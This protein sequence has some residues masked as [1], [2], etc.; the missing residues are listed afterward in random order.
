MKRRLA[1]AF[2]LLAVLSV[3]AAEPTPAPASAAPDVRRELDAVR[4]QL[5]ALDIEKALAA[6]ETILARSDLPEAARRGALDLRA[7]AHA[8][9]D[10][11][12][13][14]EKDY[15]A[16][17]AID[18]AYAPAREVTSKSAMDRF[19]KIQRSL[20]GTVHLDLDPKDAS[21][22][23]DDRPTP[24]SATGS[25]PA[26]AG[27]R[28]A[29]FTRKGFDALSVTIHVVAGQETLVQVHMVPNARGLIVRTDVDGVAVALD[30]A[31]LGVTARGAG[32][33]GAPAELLLPDVGI[34]EHE[35]RFTK[36][37]FASESVQQAVSVDLTDRSPKAL[38]VVV[39]RPASTRVAVT[40][41]SYEGDLSV[42]GARIASLP[43]TSF[44]MCPGV[45][46]IE[47][48]ASGRV[49]WSGAVD[50]PEADLTIDLTP[51]PGAALVGAEWP[52]AWDAALASWSQ[53]GR[54]GLPAGADLAATSGWSS[55]TLPN[56][57][58]LAVGVIPSGGVAGD[59]RVVL[60]SPALQRVEDRASAP[61]A[62]HPRWSEGSLGAAMADGP[63]GT[64]LVAS[65]APG[66]PAA[67]AGL[68]P[69]DRIVTISGRP[70]ASTAS[71]RDSIAA[72]APPA[73]VLLEIAPP[74]GPARRVECETSAAPAA[75]RSD[76]ESD[77]PIVR[78]AWASADAAAN[79]PESA[80]A[81]AALASLLE[82]AGRDA[83][84][85]DAWRRA[86]AIGGGALTA[87]AAYAWGA[88][89]QARGN[90]AEAIEAFTQARSGATASGDA[91]LAAAA[92]DRLADLGVA[93]R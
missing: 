58:D 44:S 83:A 26:A 6:L 11:L 13:A 73:K 85:L 66:G 47:V 80:F 2:V 67:R 89:L 38:T 5:V 17:L 28:R 55:V 8:A 10:D 32:G 43:L 65:V 45:R 18:A 92:A 15:R 14:V 1:A 54:L 36:S 88:G 76:G 20:I 77:S 41:A 39:L 87:R 70:A 86:R 81:L 90:S 42:D 33:E 9:S 57:T 82:R 24:L 19:V 46:E 21:M 25:F 72:A 69:G 48:R 51:R 68:L 64:V 27:E 37:C 91:A 22:T 63:G 30:G 3:S 59:D 49:V 34:G 50:A 4:D 61:A 40:G 12:P 29:G 84:A 23:V 78:A 7:Q 56:G 62:S 53:R 74:A 52:K 35:L 93:P 79:G 16:I 60:Y 31:A 71:A 75:P